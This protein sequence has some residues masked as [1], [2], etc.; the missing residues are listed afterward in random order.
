MLTIIIVIIFVALCI[1]IYFKQKVD[2]RHEERRERQQE[3]MDTLLKGLRK[4]QNET[5]S[6]TI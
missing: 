3:R 6:T 5:E 2:I 1:L 4:K